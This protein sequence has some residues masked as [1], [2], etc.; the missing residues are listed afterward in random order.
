MRRDEE[1]EIK[2]N[3]RFGSNE[4]QRCSKKSEPPLAKKL[5]QRRKTHPAGLKVFMEELLSHLLMS[6]YFPSLQYPL[7]A[8]V[9]IMIKNILI[10]RKESD[11]Y[12][13]TVNRHHWS[14]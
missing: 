14:R 5:V 2:G 10:R 11:T 7:A 1:I 3:G 9:S 6:L 8:P 4:R 13:A 12:L